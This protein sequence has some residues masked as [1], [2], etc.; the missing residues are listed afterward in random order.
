MTIFQILTIFLKLHIVWP[1]GF[2]GLICNYELG[3]K[4]GLKND[5][6]LSLI[7][8]NNDCKCNYMSRYKVNVMN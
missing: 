2:K 7:T 1:L 4:K 6:A 8:S 3:A 5:N